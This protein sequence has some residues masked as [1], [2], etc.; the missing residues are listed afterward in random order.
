M[1]DTIYSHLSYYQLVREEVREKVKQAAHQSYTFDGQHPITQLATA[2][3]AGIEAL[4]QLQEVYEVIT[5]IRNIVSVLNSMHEDNLDCSVGLPSLNIALERLPKWKE[6]PVDDILENHS[7]RV[8]YKQ[9]YD[10]LTNKKGNN[11]HSNS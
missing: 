1:R 11:E 2:Y 3:S 10:E 6:S 9:R 8:L 5:D 4:V 7:M